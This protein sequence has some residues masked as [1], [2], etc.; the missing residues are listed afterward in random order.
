MTV[1]RGN[2]G[3]KP[4]RGSRQRDATARLA[5]TEPTPYHHGDLRDALLAAADDELADNGV[6]G[7]TLR[8]CAR[9]AGVSH[10]APAHH[11]RDVRALLTEVAAHGFERLAEIT[12]DYGETEP[13]GSLAR[14]QAIARGYVTFADRDPHHFRLIFRVDRLDGDDERYTAAGAAAFRVPVDS[15]GEFYGSADPMAEPALA[16]RVIGLWS[17]VHG[18]SE[19]MLTG[20]FD[21]AAGGD[22]AALIDRLVPKIVG[23][24]FAGE[25]PA[26]AAGVKSPA[27]NPRG[28]RNAS[29]TR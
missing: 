17:L 24:Y 14:L 29:R 8:G 11:F 7:F 21:A 25:V 16:A 22:R 19:L 9:R 4:K 27:K 5:V 20:Q 12:R 15:V 18:F 23:Q 13:P 10:A 6:E 3:I 1:V 26:A 28:R 2:L